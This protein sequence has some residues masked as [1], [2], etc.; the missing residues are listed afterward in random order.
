MKKLLISL[1]LLVS[2]QAQALHV[3][4]EEASISITTD[5]VSHIVG[6]IDHTL[7][8]K[9]GIEFE[10]TKNLVGPRVIIINSS[11][12]EFEVGNKIL[13]DIKQEQAQ[14]VKMIC[15]MDVQASSMAFNILSHCDVR[16]ATEG[17]AGVVHKIRLYGIFTQETAKQLRELANEIDRE[18]EPFR[19]KNAK[20]M[21]LSLNE[22]D[23]W[24]D[25]ESRWTA[26][27]LHA[28]KY[29]HGFVKMQTKKQGIG[30]KK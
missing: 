11:G 15:I 1:M 22:Y 30:E 29:I 20:E 10:K 12:G 24:A 19:R 14:G 27:T 17:S 16:L 23:Y 21:H 28:R 25:K 2:T 18:D 7:L 3:Q 8:S 5:K 4:N 13:K 9:W 26:E 6:D